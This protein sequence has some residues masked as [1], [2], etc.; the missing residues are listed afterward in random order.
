MRVSFRWSKRGAGD[1]AA[2]LADRVGRARVP[3]GTKAGTIS[4]RVTDR[5]GRRSR[6]IRLVVLPVPGAASARPA[7]A[8]PGAVRAATACGSGSCRRASGGDVNADRRAGAG[9]RHRDGLREEL[10]RRRRRVGAVQPG[11]GRR[12]CTRRACAC[13]RGSSSTAP[14]RRRGGAGRERR[15]GG[16]RLP[17]HRRREPLRGPLRAGAAVRRRPAGR[18]R[19]RPIRS[20]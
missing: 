17:R 9:G 6:V 15:G 7:G 18:D 3:P 1:E 11:A 12:R 2:A 8:A 16:R 19:A 14:T 4:V 5:A 13:A 20:A 10:G